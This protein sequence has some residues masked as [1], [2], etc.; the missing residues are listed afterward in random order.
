MKAV[1]CTKYG[2]PEVLQLQ[3]VAKPVPSDNEILV[4]VSATTV[5]AGESLVRRFAVP[6]SYW[7]LAR[8]AIGWSKPRKAILGMVAAGE[9]EAVGNSVTRF[10]RGDQ[11]FAYDITRFRTYA[12]YTCLPEN[13]AIALK[14]SAVTYEEAAAI[15]YGGITALHFL[16]QGK[17]EAGQHV[18]IYG[19]SGSVGTFAVQL[20]KHFGA[21]VTGVCSTSNVALV[22][23]LGADQVID[24]TQEDWTRRGETYDVLFDAVGKTS[25]PDCLKVL[26]KEGVYLQPLAAPALSLRMRLA[27]V[28]SSKTLIGGEATPK[29]EDLIF[30]KELVEAGK[31]KP[32]I[33]R[34]YPL[35]QIV[36]AHRYVDQGHK[37]GDVVITVQQSNHI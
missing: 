37:K 31:I 24:Y 5:T 9:V 23:S 12:E 6:L 34:R 28:T 32:V 8:L 20:A 25:F 16:K 29:T 7:L 22:K 15:P 18:L 17:I 10:Q 21:R 1:I 19:A 14:P 13:S 3:E 33:D 36:E 26:K 35:E 30:L 11:V 4:K 27:G 2:P